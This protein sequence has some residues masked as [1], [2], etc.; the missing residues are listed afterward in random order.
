MLLI[1]MPSPA[2]EWQSIDFCTSFDKALHLMNLMCCSWKLSMIF[3]QRGIISS[4]LASPALFLSIPLPWKCEEFVLHGPAEQC[5]NEAY[6]ILILDKLLVTYI[7][8]STW[9]FLYASCSWRLV[10]ELTVH[11]KALWITLFGNW[12]CFSFR[13]CLI[14][15]LK[16]L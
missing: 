9:R 6:I 5:G 12:G 8:L 2:L 15:S 4:Y 7:R 1:Q 3:F 16:R 13:I 11:F 10:V 14:K